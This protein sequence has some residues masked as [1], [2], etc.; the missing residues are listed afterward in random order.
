MLCGEVAGRSLAGMRKRAFLDVPW[1]RILFGC[2]ASGFAIALV[3]PPGRM[4]PLIVVAGVL[5]LIGL[6]FHLHSEQRR[7]WEGS[8]RGFRDDLTT[9]CAHIRTALATDPQ[10]FKQL[11]QTWEELA[12]QSRWPPD[13]TTAPLKGWPERM[14]AHLT[15]QERALLRAAQRVEWIERNTVPYQQARSRM[16]DALTQ[17][18]EWSSRHAI[19]QRIGER[20]GEHRQ[21][22][23]ML[24]YLE[25][26]HADMMDRAGPT[27]EAWAS[28]DRHWPLAPIKPV[29]P[30][31]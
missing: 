17:W 14:S 11:G 25:I 31:A 22:V 1:A 28:L 4:V 29:V 16:A 24:A 9:V 26:A 13:M 10:Q 3:L 21:D 2:A 8:Y 12:S 6:R 19:R 15:E 7:E 27:P 18:A 30:G 20:I 23:V 5:A